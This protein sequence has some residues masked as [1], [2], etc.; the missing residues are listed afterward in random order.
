MARESADVDTCHSPGVALSVKVGLGG[1][2]G[3][4][5]ELQAKISR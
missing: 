3:M 2:M 4:K 1:G 5:T